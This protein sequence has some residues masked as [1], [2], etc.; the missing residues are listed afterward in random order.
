MGRGGNCLRVFWKQSEVY[1]VE[2]SES[3][4]IFVV[5]F[6]LYFCIAWITPDPGM[7]QNSKRRYFRL[8]DLG[9]KHELQDLTSQREL[10]KLRKFQKLKQ[11]TQYSLCKHPKL[12]R[13]TLAQGFVTNTTLTTHVISRDWLKHGANQR[14]NNTYLS[15]CF[16]ISLGTSVVWRFYQQYC[17]SFRGKERNEL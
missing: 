15:S 1:L 2:S 6:F 10:W 11:L 3:S 13:L 17:N 5:G 14:L 7:L 4:P 8:L 9:L 12:P 16:Y